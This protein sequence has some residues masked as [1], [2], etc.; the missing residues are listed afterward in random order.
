MF[1]SSTNSDFAY[2]QR[3]IMLSLGTRRDNPISA[4]RA[5]NSGASQGIVCDS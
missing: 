2:N 1:I 3:R 4:C 5:Q